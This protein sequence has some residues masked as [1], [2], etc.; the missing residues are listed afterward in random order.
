MEV[1]EEHKTGYKK[2]KFG[3][4]PE[5]WGLVPLGKLCKRKG[6]YGIGASAVEYNPELPT[7]LRITDIDNNGKFSPKKKAS[8]LESDWKEYLLKEGDIVFVRTG[9]TTGKSYL[10]KSKD[11]ELVFAG[12]LIRFTPDEKKLLPSYLSSISKSSYYEK[13]ISIMS[14]RSGQ[15][16]INSSEFEL[17]PILLPSV[18]EQQKIAS[19]LSDWDTAIE[20]VQKLVEKLQL[21]KKGLMQ[22]LLT[23]R[24]RMP[25]FSDKWEEREL[26]DFLESTLR[27]KDKPNEPFLALGLRS[28]GKGIFQ[29]PDFNPNSLAMTTLYEVKE[30]DLLINITFAWEHA[31]AIA[32]NEDEGGLVSHRFPTFTFKKGTSDPTFFR[33]YILQP[34]FKYMLGV[35]SPGGAGRNRVMSKKDFIKLKVNVPSYEEQKAIS[36]VL[37][38]ADQEIEKQEKYLEQLQA[39][40]KGLMQQLLTGKIRINTNTDE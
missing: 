16:G 10:Y 8:L 35:I 22:Q 30:N 31:I 3:W 18:S 2:T 1:I 33:Y 32:N 7:Y 13:W 28:H 27:P 19:I 4:I 9:S 15:P 26:G 24:K 38:K 12:F 20:N 6:K 14:V 5:D 40:K 37:N 17:L 36:N 34:R 21:R 29:K 23:G 11:G 25:G 39:Q